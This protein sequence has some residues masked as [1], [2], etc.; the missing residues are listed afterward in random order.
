MQ[1]LLHGIEATRNR[2]YTAKPCLKRKQELSQP[3]GR[4]LC[5]TTPPRTMTWHFHFLRQVRRN[6]T[7]RITKTLATIIQPPL[8]IQ[9]LDCSLLTLACDDAFLPSRGFIP[10]GK[11]RRGRIDSHRHAHNSPHNEQNYSAK[12]CL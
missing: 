5:T 8:P 1:L 4:P 12:P 9:V 10:S 11:G 3:E 6:P 7:N 2:G